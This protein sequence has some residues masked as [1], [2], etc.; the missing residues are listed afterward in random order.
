VS[1]LIAWA[2]I[3]EWTA[4][5][6]HISYLSALGIFIGA[7]FVGYVL[8]SGAA[9]ALKWLK[10]HKACQHGIRAGA[11]GGCQICLAEADRIENERKAQAAERARRHAISDSAMR[12]R[13]M[14]IERLSRAWLSHI[15]A[16]LQMDPQPFECAIAEL[17]RRL[18]YE[19]VQTPFSNDGGKD[20]I[21]KKA[22]KKYLIECKRYAPNNSIGRRDVQVFVAAMQDEK[23]DGGFYVNTGIFTRTA[24]EYA[25]KNRI[26]LYDRFALPHLVNQAYPVSTDASSASVMC[27]ECGAVTSMPVL[28]HPVTGVCSNGHSVSS[29]IVKADF[30]IASSSD[31][32]YCDRCGS[33]M[34]MV[35]GRRG[36]FWGC[37]RYPACRTSKPLARRELANER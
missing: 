2:L 15:E 14:E 13:G 21:A 1:G 34:R 29:K 12:L 23:A 28:D 10:G 8:L 26:D 25:A 24:T 35:S 11:R 30:R 37:S 5:A 7:V 16:Y 18:G 4:K 3:L 27:L 19:V 33:P 22:G 9:S 31:V 20:A 6:A 17:F 32:P 36:R